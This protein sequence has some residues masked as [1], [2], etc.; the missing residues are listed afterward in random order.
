M[1]TTEP[2]PEATT[3][4]TSKRVDKPGQHSLRFDGDDPHTVCVYCGEV[5]DAITGR[6]VRKGIS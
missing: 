6:L 5:R 2:T 1:T 4:P 3:C